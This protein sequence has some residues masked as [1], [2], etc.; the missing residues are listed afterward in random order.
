[1]K[2]EGLLS[3]ILVAVALAA[4]SVSLKLWLSAT[5]GKARHQERSLRHRREMQVFS[6]AKREQR[7][8]NPAVAIPTIRVH[9]ERRQEPVSESVSPQIT[10][11]AARPL[12]PAPKPQAH[13]R[14]SYRRGL[15]EQSVKVEAIMALD[16]RPAAIVNGLAVRVGDMVGK[17]KVI[18]ITPERVTFAY[19]NL[20][21]AKSI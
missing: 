4:P 8:I 19:K 9:E 18:L 1:M 14:P 17:L 2:R 20:R 16:G 13:L 21:F 12:L 7:L 3:L 15:V 10:P 5:V 6:G 11:E